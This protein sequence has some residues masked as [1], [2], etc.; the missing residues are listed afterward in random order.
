MRILIDECLPKRLTFELPG[1]VVLTVTDQ[2]WQ[3]KKNGELLALM[4][5]ENFE[6]FLTAD[7][8]LQYQQ[9]LKNAGIAVIVL[10]AASNRY[11]DLQQLMPSVRRQLSDGVI[12]GQIY[13]I[14]Q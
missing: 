9:N 5:A 4:K 14:K 1:N 7:Q 10:S 12:A 6:V 2:K 8:N 3:G 13:I 11:K